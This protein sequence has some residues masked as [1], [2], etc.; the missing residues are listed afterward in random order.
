[1]INS[2]RHPIFANFDLI[3]VGQQVEENNWQMELLEGLPATLTQRMAG[4][5]D[6]KSLIAFLTERLAEFGLK[7]D[8]D[9]TDRDL[10]DLE[11]A[12]QKGY[13]G[14]LEHNGA[15][16]GTLALFPLSESVAEIRKMYLLPAWRGQGLGRKMLQTLESMARQLGFTRVELETSS[17]MQTAIHLYTSSGYQEMPA[18]GC[19]NR[20]DR[21]F[22][23]LL[24]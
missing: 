11:T 12:Y 9:G 21:R 6:R 19:G 10:L 2:T 17:P 7:L 14:I 13:F 18:T 23:K 4:A 22:F 24:G 16:I 1:M 20:C 8:F 3:N 5:D 15:P